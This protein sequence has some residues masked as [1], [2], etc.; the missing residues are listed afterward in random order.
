MKHLIFIFLTTLLSLN[1]NAQSQTKNHL[2]DDT[3]HQWKWNEDGCFNKWSITFENKT[4]QTITSVTFRLVIEEKESGV[5][6][7][8]KT[9]TVNL[10]LNA[11]ETAPS[12]YFNLSQ[13]LCGLKNPDD[14]E[15]YYHYTEVI[16]FK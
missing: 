2:V 5:V 8:K 4:Q 16:S 9:H 12:P 1:L 11:N 13:E 7:Y 14:L 6:R 15:G 10:T 3:Y